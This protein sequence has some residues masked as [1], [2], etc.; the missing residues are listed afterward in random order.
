M[1]TI[2][3]FT[4]NKYMRK[5]EFSIQVT[6]YGSLN[7]SRC[8][9]ERLAHIVNLLALLSIASASCATPIIVGEEELLF[10]ADYRFA[11]H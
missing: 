10:Y 1:K 6:I 11:I 7:N 3:L 2:S 4:L 5:R 8:I 9:C